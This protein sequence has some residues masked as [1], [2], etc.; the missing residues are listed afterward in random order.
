[1]EIWTVKQWHG[2][3][4][5]RSQHAF[6]YEINNTGEKKMLGSLFHNDSTPMEN[7]LHL[8]SVKREVPPTVISRK[9]RRD[10]RIQPG[11]EIYDRARIIFSR[12]RR[13]ANSR[14]TSIV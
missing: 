3:C 13:N 11:D 6:V 2:Y 14:V 10:P 9:V 1:M 4:R 8:T 7:P 5:Y 12:A